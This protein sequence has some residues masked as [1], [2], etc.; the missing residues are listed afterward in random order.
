[1]RG[2]PGGR[3]LPALADLSPQSHGAGAG[4]DG[5]APEAAAGGAR[6]GRGG[7][8]DAGRL[9]ARGGAAAAGQESTLIERLVYRKLRSDPRPA[10]RAAEVCSPGQVRRA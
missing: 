7:R 9:G 4:G 1:M 5:E 3:P 2:A 6:A 10:V 8:G